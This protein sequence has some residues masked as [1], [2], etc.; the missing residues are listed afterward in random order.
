LYYWLT[1]YQRICTDADLYDSRILGQIEEDLTTI[2][3]FITSNG[4]AMP[5]NSDLVLDI[6][7]DDSYNFLQT[8]YYYV[9]HSSRTI[10]FLDTYEAASLDAWHEAPG[11]RTKQHLRHEIEAQYW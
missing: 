9:D 6:F 2:D 5:D 4:L 1:S 8:T 10:F 7:Y 11:A 3:N